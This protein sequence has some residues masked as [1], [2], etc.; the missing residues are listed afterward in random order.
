MKDCPGGYEPVPISTPKPPYSD[1][2]R[3]N[4]AQGEVLLQGV[5]EIDG[6]VSDLSIV[7]SP[8]PELTKLTVETV[9]KWRYKPGTCNGSPVRVYFMTSVKFSLDQ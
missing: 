7:K 4:Y 8:D 3:L 6:T 5:V 2:R 9:R 1:L